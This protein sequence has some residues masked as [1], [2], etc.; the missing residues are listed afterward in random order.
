MNQR[1]S[2]ERLTESNHRAPRSSERLPALMEKSN[3][4]YLVMPRLS[5]VASDGLWKTI[6]STIII[7]QKTLYGSTCK[8]ML[9][10]CIWLLDY[11]HDNYSLQ[12]KG[13]KPVAEKRFSK[14]M[15]NS[16]LTR[17]EFVGRMIAL[18]FLLVKKN[19]CQSRPHMR[20]IVTMVL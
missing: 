7:C 12:T 13:K 4:Q 16:K 10:I 8:V 2:I 14:G 15:W 17:G 19:W 1:P 3:P 9:K 5:E 20:F 6:H 11:K 18:R